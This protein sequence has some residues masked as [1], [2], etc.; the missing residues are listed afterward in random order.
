MAEGQVSLVRMPTSVSACKSSLHESSELICHRH[1]GVHY[2][3]TTQY[4]IT[5]LISSCGFA[6]DLQKVE[7]SS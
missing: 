4:V 6:S 3:P 7:L 2:S 5:T 1:Y